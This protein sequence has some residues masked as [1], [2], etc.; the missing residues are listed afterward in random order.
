[1]NET[2]SK[3]PGLQR[4][5]R[6]AIN[7]DHLMICLAVSQMRG[8][9]GTSSPSAAMFMEFHNSS[10]ISSENEAVPFQFALSEDPGDLTSK[11]C[12]KGKFDA[13]KPHSGCFC[14]PRARKNKTT[15]CCST[16]LRAR[17]KV[18]DEVTSRGRRLMARRHCLSKV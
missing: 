15:A 14:H 3:H 18:Y 9:D 16:D 8:K 7:L 13:R 6:C 1:M 10:S 11:F 17:E 4:P 5:Y 12:S 2:E